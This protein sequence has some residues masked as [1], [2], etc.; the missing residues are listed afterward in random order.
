MRHVHRPPA[1][2]LLADGTTVEIR[3]LGPQD[4]QAVLDLHADGMS[5]ESR[6]LR[7]FVV[8]RNAPRQTAD[9]LCGPPGS[10][11]LTLG[12]WVGEELVG[13][14]DCVLLDDLPET[15]ELALAVVAGF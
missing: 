12:A 4:H 13:E 9:R 5:E 2:E 15:A 8:S 11:L 7:F 10:G 14:A 3:P 1:A 6:R